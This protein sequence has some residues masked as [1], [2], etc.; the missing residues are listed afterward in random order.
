[1]G[2]GLGLGLG[3]GSGFGSG[4]LRLLGPN[5]GDAACQQEESA[6]CLPKPTPLPRPRADEQRRQPLGMRLRRCAPL[7]H[8]ERRVGVA[9]RCGFG[10][11]SRPALDPLRRLVE[12]KGLP[13]ERRRAADR[14]QGELVGGVAAKVAPL[15]EPPPRRG[16][17]DAERERRVRGRVGVA[18]RVRVACW[19]LGF[20]CWGLA[21]GCW[22]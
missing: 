17:I 14:R 1:M 15:V 10:V 4:V 16:L 22:G 8:A 9:A 13:R 21:V 18:A 2:L 7:E 6:G 20:G 19:V 5:E 12:E 3:L 11:A